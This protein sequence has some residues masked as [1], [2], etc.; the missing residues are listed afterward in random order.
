MLER[1]Q[2]A[3]QRR[4]NFREAETNSSIITSQNN[5][6]YNPEQDFQNHTPED[7]YEL[8]SRAPK[9]I[10]FLI[11]Q[12]SALTNDFS[13]SCWVHRASEGA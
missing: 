11:F 12:V 6:Y 8:K 7:K 5:Y 4:H 2:P 3:S 1:L 13:G 9:P 10:W